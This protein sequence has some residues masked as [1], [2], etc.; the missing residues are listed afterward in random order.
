MIGEEEKDLILK[1]LES[2]QFS[3]GSTVTEFE[4]LFAEYLG[5]KHVVATSSG[6][7]ALLAAVMGAGVRPK[8]R[9]LTTP[10]TFVAP[11]NAL[12]FAGATP[13]FVDIDE[14]TFNLDVRRLEEALERHPGVRAVLVV[15]LYGLMCNMSAI[16]D[17]AKRNNLITIEDCAQA[18][19][20]DLWGQKAGTW[21]NVA[22]FSFYATKNMT[23]GEGGAVATND[24]RIAILARQFID[25]G[26][27]G[28][29][30]HVNLGYNFRM[31]ALQAALG[32]AQL[33]KL[34]FFNRKRQE[35]E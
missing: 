16:K 23:T 28:R 2:G 34:D 17:L 5:V 6:T 24:E 7:T 11:V 9:I 27:A 1:V 13:L 26:Q 15:H 25:H 33:K 31:S 29:Y 4:S 20:A 21:G 19:G 10:F 22:A 30:H 12:L 8:D 18:H 3:G 32:V 14:E 35:N